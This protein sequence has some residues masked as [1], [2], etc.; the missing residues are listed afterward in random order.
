MA[1]KRIAIALTAALALGA[2]GGGDGD[3]DEAGTTEAPSATTV[4][5]DEATTTVAGDTTTPS[6]GAPTTTAPTTTTTVADLGPLGAIDG[7]APIEVLTPRSGNGERPL[8]AWSPVAGAADY[9]VTL[10]L[11]DGTAYWAWHGAETEVWLGG[12][13]EQPPSGAEG[14]IL[15]GPMSLQ[16]IAVDAAGAPVGA[17]A[18]TTIAP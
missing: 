9:V 1:V 17:S 5:D 14:P 7:V 11:P 4:E 13:A 6:T 12:T 10:Q 15:T 18:A 8:L 2:C 3:D 16:V